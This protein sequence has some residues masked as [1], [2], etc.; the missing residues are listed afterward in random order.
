MLRPL[1]SCSSRRRHPPASAAKGKAEVADV[2]IDRLLHVDHSQDR[3]EAL[4]ASHLCHLQMLKGIAKR[5]E[6]C[7][8][9][10]SKRAAHAVSGLRPSLTAC[11]ALSVTQRPARQG[12]RSSIALDGKAGGHD[13]EKETL[14]DSSETTT[15]STTHPGIEAEEV[16]ELVHRLTLIFGWHALRYSE[17]RAWFPQ[18]RTPFG[19]PQCVPPN[20]KT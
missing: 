20:P 6:N 19:V 7:S 15:Q 10:L 2:V 11:A 12:W 8:M 3:D 4:E 16:S 17:G 1:P 5:R 13:N 18:L 14:A 9:I